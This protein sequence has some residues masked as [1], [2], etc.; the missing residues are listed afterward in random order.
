MQLLRDR[1][2]RYVIREISGDLL[3]VGVKDDNIYVAALDTSDVSESVAL[4]DTGVAA[5]IELDLDGGCR[6]EV[7]VISGEIVLSAYKKLSQ[8]IWRLVRIAADSAGN[9]TRTESNDIDYTPSP[10]YVGSGN[11]IA[12]PREPA[13]HYQAPILRTFEGTG[14]AFLYSLT[15]ILG[16]SS[17]GEAMLQG[18]RYFSWSAGSAYHS[19]IVSV[20]SSGQSGSITVSPGVNVYYPWFGTTE[21]AYSTSSRSVSG[22]TYYDAIS[23]S[24]PFTSTST[25]GTVLGDG[26]NNGGN[27][28]FPIG[29]V[30]SPL[31]ASRGWGYSVFN[32][33]T[34]PTSPP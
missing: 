17:T 2:G 12:V 27:V 14:G 16:V 4:T 21:V 13:N 10:A 18:P 9:C 24:A 25:V 26:L 30:I 23:V 28:P 1:Y 33:D 22:T 15:T 5:D 29:S 31:D 34:P 6:G 8:Y 32:T 7:R 11:P 20:D 19:K 3:A